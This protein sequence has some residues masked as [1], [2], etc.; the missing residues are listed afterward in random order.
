MLYCTSSP[1]IG[2][3]L[4]NF[5]LGGRWN[6]VGLPVVGDLPPLREGRHDV[7]VL[8]VSG[9]ALV[10]AVVAL[11]YREVRVLAPPPADAARGRLGARPRP[12]RCERRRDELRQAAQIDGAK[13]APL[14]LDLRSNNRRI[15]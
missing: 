3:P 7:R 8:V 6:R 10:D 14:K 13:P 9:Q 2:C 4:W 5:T 1:V 12:G 11:Q 15:T